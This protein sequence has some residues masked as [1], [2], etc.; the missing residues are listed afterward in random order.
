[1]FHRGSYNPNIA[2]A[3]YNI[4]S[5]LLPYLLRFYWSKCPIFSSL[6]DT[7]DKVI[8]APN[9]I[10]SNCPQFT[11]ILPLPH[12]SDPSAYLK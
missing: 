9:V 7:P 3:N 4:F 10:S 2:V 1:M 5:S 12:R 6:P 8:P 11:N